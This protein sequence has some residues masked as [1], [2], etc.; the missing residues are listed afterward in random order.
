MPE[1]LHRLTYD[2]TID[3][4]VDVSLRL[5][6]RTHAIRK[7]LHTYVIIA[8]IVAAVAGFAAWMYYVD[9]SLM[10]MVFAAVVGVLF[11]IVFAA[12]FRRLLEKEIRKQQRKVVAE[13]FGGK[14]SIQSEI[15][16]RPDAIWV[17]QAGME[18]LF[19]WALCTSVDNNPDDIEMNFAPGICVIRHKHFASPAD[20]QAFLETARRLAKP[21]TPS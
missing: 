10:H 20:Q 1:V 8:G 18:M 3:D 15:E 14:P 7:Q 13:Q 4:A 6:H 5:A 16:L 19:P 21:T 17:R 11:G 9:T 12:I 2:V